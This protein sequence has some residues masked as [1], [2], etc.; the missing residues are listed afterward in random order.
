MVASS[1]TGL[2]NHQTHHTRNNVAPGQL[3]G[4]AQYNL[5]KTEN[6]VQRG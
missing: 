2:T 6:D 3:A 1:A 4:L 5:N